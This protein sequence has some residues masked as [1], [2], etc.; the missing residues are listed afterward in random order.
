VVGGRPPGK[1]T[2]ALLTDIDQHQYDACRYIAQRTSQP[3]KDTAWLGAR[4]ELESV[5]GKLK[6]ARNTDEYCKAF[7]K[8]NCL[9][10]EMGIRPAKSQAND[11]VCP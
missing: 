5:A 10:E 4:N 2:T 7:G 3:V 6:L 11:I 1:K 8:L 9:A